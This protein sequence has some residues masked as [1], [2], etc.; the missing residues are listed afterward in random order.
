M[1]RVK[2]VCIEQLDV[3]APVTF[4]ALSHLGSG[5]CRTAVSCF[6]AVLRDEIISLILGNGGSACPR[7]AQRRRHESR[8]LDT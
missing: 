5:P 2:D 1:V 8:I 6:T 3:V 4:S 7:F